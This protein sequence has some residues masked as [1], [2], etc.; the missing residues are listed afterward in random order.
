MIW[1]EKYKDK[2]GIRYDTFKFLFNYAYDH[3]LKEILETGTAR[4]KQRLFFSK[5]NWKDGMSSLLFAEYIKLVNG[6]LWTC[7]I[8]KANI[9][10]AQKFLKNFQNCSKIFEHF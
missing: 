7:D 2:L 8:D 5:P 4:G 9:K 1:L 3:N 10:N 6:H